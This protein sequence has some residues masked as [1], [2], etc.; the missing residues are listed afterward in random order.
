MDELLLCPTRYRHSRTRRGTILVLE[1]LELVVLL[2]WLVL[3][4]VLEV[5]LLVLLVLEVLQLLQLL[6]LLWYQLI[7][8]GCTGDQHPTPK[9]VGWGGHGHQGDGCRLRRAGEHL[10]R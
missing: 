4:L 9:G 7:Q 2:L 10:R 1:L 3:V 5:L 8:V 6:L